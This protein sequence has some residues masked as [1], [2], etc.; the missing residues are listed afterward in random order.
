M[1]DGTSI[2]NEKHN[3]L[4][5][6]CL[7]HS[8]YLISFTTHGSTA[9]ATVATADTNIMMVMGR[10]AYSASGYGATHGSKGIGHEAEGRGCTSG[11][12]CSILT[13]LSSELR[14]ASPCCISNLSSFFRVARTTE[15]A[16]QRV[17]VKILLLFFMLA[18]KTPLARA[19]LQDKT[20]D[21]ERNTP[22]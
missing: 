16:F 1:A 14:V 2:Y 20:T 11:H 3:L 5:H 19:K 17:C 6:S 7:L 21:T 10:R 8:I 18:V 22:K 13:S 12:T 15:H 4:L 9:T